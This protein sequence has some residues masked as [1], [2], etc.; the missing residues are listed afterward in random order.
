[1]LWIE[2][3][4]LRIGERSSFTEQSWR[5]KRQWG[6]QNSDNSDTAKLIFGKVILY[7]ISLSTK[8]NFKNSK[9]SKLEIQKLEFSHQG[10]LCLPHF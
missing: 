3:K 6:C 4:G 10:L 8:R 5:W 2:Q 1:M 7:L 9:I